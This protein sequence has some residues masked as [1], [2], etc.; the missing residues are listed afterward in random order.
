MAKWIHDDVLDQSLNYV[1]NNCTRMTACSQQPADY[2]EANATYKLADVTMASGDFTVGDGDASGRKVNVAAKAAV[3]IDADGTANHVALL[4]VS[5][6]KLLA[7][8]TCQA[9][10][11]T[12]GGTVDFPTWDLE[13]SDP[14]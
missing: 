5:N 4:D 10:Q 12:S 6:T 13:A 1:K 8:T 2:T 3:D 7:V 14:S 9:N 11:L